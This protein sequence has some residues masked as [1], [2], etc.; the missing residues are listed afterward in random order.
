MSTPLLHLKTA[1]QVDQAIRSEYDRLVIIRFGNNSDPLCTQVDEL[2]GSVSG[3][4]QSLAIVYKVDITQ[5]TDFNRLY[6]LND[7]CNVV[8]FFRNE[9]ISVDMGVDGFDLANYWSLVGHQ[10]LVNLVEMTLVAAHKRTGH[11][12]PPA[13]DSTRCRSRLSERRSLTKRT[14]FG[15][16]DA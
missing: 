1:R 13:I 6:G 3:K 12:I 7:P 2:F 4:I 14:T 10:D 9:H 5:L 8:F 15:I 16:L 11:T